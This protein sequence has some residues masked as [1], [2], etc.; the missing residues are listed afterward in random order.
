MVAFAR[1]VAVAEAIAALSVERADDDVERLF[2]EFQVRHGQVSNSDTVFENFKNYVH[3]VDKHPTNPVLNSGSDLSP[4]ALLSREQFEGTYRN[5]AKRLQEARSNENSPV[6][7]DIPTSFDWRERGMVSP[8][9]DQGQCG[10]CWAFSATGLLESAWAVAGHGMELLSEQELVSCDRS[11]TGNAGCD[12]G[13]PY[14]AVDFVRDHG[15][16]T[17]SSYPYTSGQGDTGVC[18][19]NTGSLAS[20]QASGF[21][22]VQPD[23]DGMAAWVAQNGPLSILVDAMSDLWWAYTAGIL[24][25]CSSTDTDH[26]VL[27]V[28]FGVQAGQKY[29]IVKN[30]WGSAWGESG[31][32]RLERGSNQCGLTDQPLGAVVSGSPSPAPSPDGWIA[33]TDNYFYSAQQID[34]QE[35]M[36]I[37]D[38][39]K[40]CAGLSGCAGFTVQGG[41]ESTAS[42]TAYFENG[43][44]TVHAAGWT[45]FRNP[46]WTPS[47]TPVPPT[48]PPPTPPPTPAPKPMPDGWIVHS[49]VYFHSSQQIDMQDGMSMEAAKEHCVALSGCVGFTVNAAA[50]ETQFTQVYFENGLETV[51]AAGWTAFE[52][53][54]GPVPTPRPTPRPTPTPTPSPSPMCPEDADLVVATD[55]RNE[56][57]WTS[58][59]HGLKIPPSATQY[60]DYIA[61]GYFGYIWS[62]SEGDYDC[63]ASARKSNNGQNNF[64]V[65]TDGEHGV[66]I[67]PTSTADCNNLS[68]GR[69]GVIFASTSVP[70]QV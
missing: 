51:Y 43:I 18:H 39:K 36:S 57:L 47:P 12:G 45:A 50:D 30:S 20:I 7:V 22:L 6:V 46:Q 60:C 35:Q 3:L 31:Y 29:W 42:F 62:T 28:G 15:L 56:C 5:C 63:A 54:V 9:K 26:A 59:A 17:E 49:D 10:S 64:C 16:K 37:D 69:I 61:N 41:E 44:D 34:V 2:E 24:S 1:F 23:E 53:P 66:V 40:H 21:S 11:S 33:Y 32:I 65:W 19:P 68:D 58:G 13:W 27:A 55:G 70:V 14:L 8:V 67:P 25:T 4:L 52:R 38:A 48:P